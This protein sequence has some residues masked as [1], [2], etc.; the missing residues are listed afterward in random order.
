M[1]SGP[2]PPPLATMGHRLQATVWWSHHETYSEE[3]DDQDARAGQVPTARAVHLSSSWRTLPPRA[4]A[5]SSYPPRTHRREATPLHQAT[6]RSA[7]QGAET[8]TNRGRSRQTS[9]FDLFLFVAGHFSPCLRFRRLLASSSARFPQRRQLR[10]PAGV[11]GGV[12]A[13][14]CQQGSQV[15]AGRV[16][17]PRATSRRPPEAVLRELE[18]G[19][20]R[21]RCAAR[22]TAVLSCSTDHTDA[23]RL[24]DRCSGREAG[25]A[26]SRGRLRQQPVLRQKAPVLLQ[27][28]GSRRRAPELCSA[29]TPDQKESTGEAVERKSRWA[30]LACG[31][32]C[33]ARGRSAA[34][35]RSLATRS[36]HGAGRTGGSRSDGRAGA[37]AAG[38]ALTWSRRW[39]SAWCVGSACARAA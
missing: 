26:S 16:P 19:S 9:F 20:G 3:L 15:C 30:R 31:G 32:S 33:R 4:A 36:S 14:V 18:R 22:R 29:L 25:R 1:L 38:A 35:S 21:Q 17:Q 10:P 39:A 24:S 13:A 8:G 12:G 27:P 6:A 2:V 34:F 5:A 7:K 11:S 37:L 28:P 23:E